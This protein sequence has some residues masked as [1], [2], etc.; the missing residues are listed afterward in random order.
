MRK[1][2]DRCARGNSFSIFMGIICVPFPQLCPGFSRSLC[3][4]QCFKY[5]WDQ[6]IPGH[7][8]EVT[9]WNDLCFMQRV[10]NSSFLF[11]FFVNG[12]CNSTNW[13][14]ES[15]AER[16]TCSLGINLIESVSVIRG[17]PRYDPLLLTHVTFVLP[18]CF[19]CS[20]G[21]KWVE[22][23]VISLSERCGCGSLP[24]RKS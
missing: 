3:L 24:H 14:P 8:R 17:S 20:Q 2:E 23:T 16:V 15:S 9:Q 6:I 18:L 21:K 22:G 12:R 1:V 7:E 11:C 19:W 13:F 10:G 5:N 4:I